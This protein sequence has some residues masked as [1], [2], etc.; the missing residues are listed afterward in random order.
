[1]GSDT[2]GTLHD[3][4]RNRNPNV[5]KLERNADGLWLNNNWANPDNE[6]NPDNEFAFRLRKSFLSA[7]EIGAVF[8]FR[9]IEAVLPA[10][11]HL[12][13]FLQFYGHILAMLVG[14]QFAFPS[15]R[16]EEFKP[17]SDED[18]LRHLFQFFLFL[19]KICVI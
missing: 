16:N 19:G 9:I 3:T 10:A 8:L 6:W 18:T 2:D 7:L 13:D 17:I 5:F 4:D 15:Y 12:A 1:M 14:N 11:Q